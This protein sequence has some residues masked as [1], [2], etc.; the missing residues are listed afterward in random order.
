MKSQSTL[1]ILLLAI[2]T[3][4]KKTTNVDVKLS[5]SGK[6]TYKLTDDAGKGLP[7]VKVSLFDRLG[8]Y[9]NID[10][11]LDEKLTDP[12]GQI[13]FGDLNPNN[14]LLVADSTTVNNV[15]YI[16]REY[17]QVITG[18]VKHKETK[19]TDHS[20]T[21]IVT[22]KSYSNKPL[23]NIGVMMIPHNKFIYS[24]STASHLKVADFSKIANEAGVVSF[25]IPSDKLYTIYFYNVTTD[26]SE[27]Y[28][29]VVSVRKGA[30]VNYTV[31]IN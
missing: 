7:N 17:V 23:K 26:A 24:S 15:D 21:F 27:G 5:T 29:D 30:T 9:A 18:A 14:Y 12:D 13:D 6:L 4:C 11:L 31:Y 10:I 16:V 22:V 28:N 1:L 20:G 3:S 25:K 19:V 2:F 8:Y